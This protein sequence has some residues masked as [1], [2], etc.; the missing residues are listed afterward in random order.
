[1]GFRVCDVAVAL[2]ALRDKG[3]VF[4]RP[5]HLALDEKGIWTLPGAKGQVAWMRDPEGNL[6]SITTV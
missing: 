2:E 3:A 6:L 5:D 1:L 4:H